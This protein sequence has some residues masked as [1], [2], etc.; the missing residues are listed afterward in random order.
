MQLVTVI[1]PVYNVEKYLYK[2]ISSIVEQSYRNL[3]IILVDDGSDD[4]SYSICK[5][6]SK[7][8]TRINVYHTKNLGLSH[9]RNVGLDHAN[10]EYISFVDSDDYIHK[11]MIKTMLLKAD[12]ADLVI[13][14]YERVSDSKELIQD[15]KCLK[16]EYWSA[17]SFWQYYYLEGLRVFCCVAW[18][19]LYKKNL[20]D[21]VRYPLNKIHEDEYVIKDI[22]NQCNKVKVITDLL[23]YYVQRENS[24]MHKK[25]QGNLEEAE[26]YLGRCN[27]FQKNNLVNILRENLNEIP[28]LLINGFLENKNQT[29]AKIRFYQLKEE[30]SFFVKQYLKRNP[31][32]KL[33]LKDLMLSIPKIYILYI[34]AKSNILDKP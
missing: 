28:G 20:F 3:E 19:K 1:V 34:K 16:D 15:K 9:A 29:N 31:S 11:D 5:D 21:N 6:F 17:K 18:N 27:E 12:D 22:I 7:R 23:Y 24:I 4:N 26:A 30:Y 10:G 32:I 25:Y 13:C 8:D 33:Y 2:C 14:N